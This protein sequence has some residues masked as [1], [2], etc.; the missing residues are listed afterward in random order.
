MSRR[1]AAT[2]PPLSIEFAVFRDCYFRRCACLFVPRSS[3]HF[4]RWLPVNLCL[5][6]SSFGTSSPSWMCQVSGPFPPI[7]SSLIRVLS[8]LFSG[9]SLLRLSTQTRF[10]IRQTIRKYHE[11]Q[12]KR[13]NSSTG[14]KEP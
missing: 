3:S 13:A 8:S 1:S 11:N 10:T 2:S 5:P 9:A 7:L 12:L 14:S 4:R 6:L